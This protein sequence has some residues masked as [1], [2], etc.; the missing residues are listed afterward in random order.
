MAMKSTAMETSLCG[1]RGAVAGLHAADVKSSWLRTALSICG[2]CFLTAVAAQVRIPVPGT[3]IPMTLQAPAVLLAA[4]ILTPRNAVGSALLYLVVGAAGVPVFAPGS[5]GL[6]G[7]TGGFL[8]GFVACA[9]ITATLCR[10]KPAAAWR[11]CFAGVAGYVALFAL[12]FFWHGVWIGDLGLSV[13]SGL[14]AFLPKAIVSI[15]MTVA[16]V[17]TISMGVRRLRRP[18]ESSR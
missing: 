9:W 14:A 6:A 18:S 11:L 5:L 1:A 17:L 4:F 15:G 10:N 2:F 7:P 16:L 12:G 8:V 13:R 3:L